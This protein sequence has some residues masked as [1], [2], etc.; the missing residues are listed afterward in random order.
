MLMQRFIAKNYLVHFSLV[1]SRPFER[2]KLHF[3]GGFPALWTGAQLLPC[4]ASGQ[5]PRDQKEGQPAFLFLLSRAL[6]SSQ[7]IV[8]FYNRCMD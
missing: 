4:W 5:Q 8:H 6:P 3:Q 1:Q 2:L 7:L